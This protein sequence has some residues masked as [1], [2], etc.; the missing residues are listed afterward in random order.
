[1]PSICLTEFLPCTRL[2]AQELVTSGWMQ[3]YLWDFVFLPGTQTAQ[4]TGDLISLN[5]RDRV[6]GELNSPPGTS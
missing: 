4:V 1:M 6:H 5:Q 2:C 3:T